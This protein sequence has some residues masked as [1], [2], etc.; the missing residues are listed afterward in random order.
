MGRYGCSEGQ[1]GWY[2]TRGALRQRTWDSDLVPESNQGALNALCK[3]RHGNEEW[4]K[5]TNRR[6]F[7]W[8]AAIIIRRGDRRTPPDTS[9]KA[10]AIVIARITYSKPQMSAQEKATL[11][12][13]VYTR[14]SAS[15]CVWMLGS[16]F[17]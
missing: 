17:S 6:E 10:M 14:K 13:Y 8:V 9:G 2:V 7:R 1:N 5:R 4:I 12:V 16:C 3:K 15:K 11:R